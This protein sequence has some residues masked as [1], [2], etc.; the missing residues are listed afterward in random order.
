M[1]AEARTGAT[2]AVAT[3]LCGVLEAEERLYVEFRTLLQRERECMVA[4]RSE[5]LEEIVR[6]KATLA[7]EARLLEETRIAVS[8]ELAQLLGFRESGVTLSR[9]CDAMHGGSPALRAAH[10]RLVALLG[11]V[12]ELLDA[13]RVFAGDAALQVRGALR[14]LGRMLPLEATYQPGDGLKERRPIPRPG[15]LVRRSA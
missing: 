7:D 3:R 1:T 6:E 10:T 12:R 15:R 9:I 14:V 4:L 8:E 11:A 2:D 13:N 5:A